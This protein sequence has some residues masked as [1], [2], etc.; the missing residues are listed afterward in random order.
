[1]DVSVDVGVDDSESVSVLVGA[2]VFSLDWPLHPA[3]RPPSPAKIVRRRYDL[4]AMQLEE[5]A[6]LKNPSIQQIV[7]C[8]YT[9]YCC[10]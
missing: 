5:A 10:Y 1:M 6:N 8:I 7:D 2:G 3:T 4:S 9:L